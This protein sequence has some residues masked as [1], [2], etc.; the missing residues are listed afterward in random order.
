[1]IRARVQQLQTSVWNPLGAA[2]EYFAAP[3][4]TAEIDA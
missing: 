2:N 1:M 4:N 3:V